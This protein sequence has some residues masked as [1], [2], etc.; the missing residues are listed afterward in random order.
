M[1]TEQWNLYTRDGQLT[2]KIHFRGE[3][4]PAGYYH[5]AIHLW[6]IDEKGRYLIQQRAKT[7]TSHPGVW[8]ATGGSAIV[9]ESSL[10]AVRRETQEELG[11]DL[12]PESLHLT[13]RFVRNN[14]FVDLWKTTVH[15][16]ILT[17]FSPTPEVDAIDFRYPH[18]I[19][20]MLRTNRFFN[21][22]AEYF[23]V[24]GIEV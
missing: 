23:Q 9:G 8:A 24:L 14:H 1:I 22:W 4:I 3:P 12:L 18:E 15:S 16:R 19:A 20:Q 2:D 13:R 6:P 10:D 7:L 17:D 11:L 5:L 21:Y